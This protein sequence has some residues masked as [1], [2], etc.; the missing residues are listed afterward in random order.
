[1][2]L[3]PKLGVELA[4]VIDGLLG[5]DTCAGAGDSDADLR[6]KENL[7]GGAALFS[8]VVGADVATADGDGAA[9]FSTAGEEIDPGV[10]FND[11]GVT[12]NDG[13]ENALD[14]CFGIGGG[15]ALSS[16]L[17]VVDGD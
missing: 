13:S 11:D 5:V 6:V 12:D 2:E 8:P 10:L 4:V 14:D 3:A 17:Y 15:A 1:M 16:C 9:G 7:L